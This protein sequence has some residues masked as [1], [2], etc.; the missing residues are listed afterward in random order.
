VFNEHTLFR[1]SRTATSG[2][3][4]RHFGQ[5]APPLRASRI[6]VI[7]TLV[8]CGTFSQCTPVHA[9]SWNV[10]TSNNGQ[11]LVGSVDAQGVSHGPYPVLWPPTQTGWGDPIG[12]DP[13]TSATMSNSGTVIFT[14]T[15][16]G[17]WLHLP[18]PAKVWVHE[19]ALAEWGAGGDTRGSK[20]GS[21]STG[22]TDTIT[23]M[24]T[25]DGL[26]AGQSVS[27]SK[28]ESE[29]SSSGTFTVTISPQG[30]LSLSEPPLQPGDNPN[31]SFQ[32]GVVDLFTGTAIGD[33]TIITNNDIELSFYKS[34]DPDTSE[35]IATSHDR[36][37]DG[38]ISTDSG[39]TWHPSGSSTPEGWG[40]T[41]SPFNANSAFALPTYSWTATDGGF[42]YG[43]GNLPTYP[44]GLFTLVKP[45]AASFPLSVTITVKVTGDEAGQKDGNTFTV[46]YHLPLEK[47]KLL[48]T[49]KHGD[50]IQ[51]LMEDIGPGQQEIVKA[52]QATKL[53]VAGAVDGV[54]AI[55]TF[56]GQEELAFAAELVK[57]FAEF[58]KLEYD[59]SGED[60]YTGAANSGAEW[61]QALAD[62]MDGYQVIHIKECPALHRADG[63]HW[64][65]L[66][67]QVVALR[68][69][70]TWQADG[71]D[72]HGFD[73]NDNHRVTATQ[74]DNVLD[75][76]FYDEF[77]P[78]PPGWP[79]FPWPP[80]QTG[81]PRVSG[82]L[83]PTR[84]LN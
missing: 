61:T 39:V 77:Q 57:S 54:A 6:A 13:G 64:C 5:V 68:T 38:S 49:V 69:D 26:N 40:V 82:P 33:H 27:G 17:G 18:P 23:D 28:W 31:Y 15:W 52:R 41:D 21:A 43:S 10:T 80:V 84:T 55:F 65:K 36:N 3:S 4:H 67:I 74:T 2:K 22:L 12:A 24:S 45:D 20:T 76:P 16:D 44:E 58:T 62:N 1:A 19:K 30:T 71:Y 48:S 50:S 34:A 14:Y 72:S 73:G 35:T 32:T 29:D 81:P 78:I 9:Q 11:I 79:V 70:R 42:D 83:P 63:W 53:D 56:T 59:V 46:N 47:T 75:Q 7:A 51:T 66:S 60:A 8:V 37:S 25:P